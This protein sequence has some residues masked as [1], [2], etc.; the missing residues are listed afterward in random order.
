M[1]PE[2]RQFHRA[3]LMAFRHA[4]QHVDEVGE[5]HAAQVVLSLDFGIEMLLKAA[6][7]ERRESIMERPGRSISLLIALKRAGPFRNGSVVE[8][9]REHRDTLQH[10]AAYTDPATAN[11]LY[12][13][14]I[15]FVAELLQQAFSQSV[16]DELLLR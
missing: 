13:G 11:D 14:A 4:R 2:A 12:E 5:L 6:L 15:L 8:V 16:P 10:F 7:L 1:R 3:A 9:L